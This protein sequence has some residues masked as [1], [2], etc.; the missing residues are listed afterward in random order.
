MAHNGVDPTIGA[1]EAHWGTKN[2]AGQPAQPQVLG[3]V[4]MVIEAR[5][6]L[7]KDAT[8]ERVADELRAGGVGASLEDVRTCWDKGY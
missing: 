7:G 6:R 4:R 2:P 8:P 1:G 5:D 3:L